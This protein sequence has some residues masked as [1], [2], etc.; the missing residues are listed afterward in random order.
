[1]EFFYLFHLFLNIY[2]K[3]IKK[4]R[5]EQEKENAQQKCVPKIIAL[6]ANRSR[7]YGVEMDAKH[8]QRTNRSIHRNAQTWHYRWNRVKNLYGWNA[9][10]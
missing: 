9:Y 8:I 6:Q 5:I 1:M 7:T 3:R 10:N 2:L 4:K